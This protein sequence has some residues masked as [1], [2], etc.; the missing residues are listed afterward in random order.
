MHLFKKIREDIVA[1]LQELVSE[2]TLP[3]LSFDAVTAEPPRESE[4][5]DVATNAA[6]V[7]AKPAKKNPRQ[8]AELIKA[9]LEKYDY[10]TAIEIAGP[11]FINLKISVGILHKVILEVLRK[12]V[13]YGDSQI[14]KGEKIN[15]EYVSTNPT[16][17]IH[18][19]H[20]RGAIYG[21]T[22]AG[23]LTKAGFKVTKEY[24]IN[25]AG[26]QIIKLVDSALLRY[27]ETMGE[28]IEIPEGLYP[29]E[30]LI[31]VGKKLAEKYGKKLTEIPLE[32]A[33]AE[34]RD[35]VVSEMMEIIKSD[36][37]LLG[38]KHDVFTSEKKLADEE[39][40]DEAFMLL[41]EK[42]LI[43]QGVL[44]PPRG[45]ENEEWEQKELTLFRS[46]QFGDD[47]DR[48][49][50]KSDGSWAYMAPDVAYHHHKIKRGFNNMILVLGTDHVGYQKRLKAA[51]AALSDQKAN[52]IVILCQMVNL[53]ENG[54][55]IKMSKRA[56]NFLTV[57][58]L[59]EAVGKDVIRFIMLTRSNN[60]VLDFDLKKV[61]EQS[62][63]NPVFYVQYSHTRAC[64]VLRK[65]A[66]EIPEKE[67]LNIAE[68]EL[69]LLTDESE[70]ALI[71]LIAEWPRIVESAAASYE[72]HRIA[73]YLHDLAASFHGL[74]NKGTENSSLRF[75]IDD[76]IGLS[77]AR[78]AMVKALKLTI[79][80]GLLLLGVKPLEEM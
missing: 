47:S 23:L 62:K 14:G 40:V 32:E 79:A 18:V 60:M 61:T 2:G 71:K 68:K 12:G 19:G 17:P 70:I 28:K 50:K 53:L 22:L 31:P 73:F 21:D 44:P 7:L 26:A 27:R 48:P 57:R 33:R 42:G 78:L 24:Y 34:I 3:H 9:K 43:Y 41:Q 38:I 36:L 46:S 58:D 49:M 37:V 64:S 8:L 20:A 29:G 13:N 55:P 5:G 30:Y 67:L 1:T 4:H 11:G 54:M 52:L 15:I 66:E 77:K 39:A 72:P 65:N 74:W 80:S 63:D 59:A 35:F 45:K 10:I 51:V 76:N 25:D 69:A 16:G 75:F 56:G 6:M